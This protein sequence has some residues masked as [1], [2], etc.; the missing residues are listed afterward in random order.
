MTEKMLLILIGGDFQYIRI[1]EWMAVRKK[2]KESQI[3]RIYK[4]SI[5]L[6]WRQRARAYF[7]KF[8]C[9]SEKDVKQ[10]KSS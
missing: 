8:I 9:E 1:S 6:K 2:M 5:W 10:E 3:A 4:V 7:T